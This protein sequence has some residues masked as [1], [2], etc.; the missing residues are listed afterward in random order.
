M[1]TPWRVYDGRRSR[2]NEPIEEVHDAITVEAPLYIDLNDAPFTM[3]MQT[4]GAE[5]FLVR[6]LL[7][8]ESVN[9]AP[10]LKYTQEETELGTVARVDLADAAK[11]STNRRLASTSS[12]GLCGK[13]SI[14][15]MFDGSM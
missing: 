3:T 5:R 15:K 1:M 6:G 10:F 9:E 7:F 8:A 14:K 12:C 4:P 2:L 13:Q 11:T